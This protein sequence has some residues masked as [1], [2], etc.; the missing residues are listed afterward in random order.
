MHEAAQHC[1][2]FLRH[3]NLTGNIVALQGLRQLTVLKVHGAFV[4]GDIEVLAQLPALIDLDLSKT[5]VTGT[6]DSIRL[7]PQKNV[8]TYRP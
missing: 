5:S 7:R 1:E 8:V 4:E 2:V 3:R 6:L